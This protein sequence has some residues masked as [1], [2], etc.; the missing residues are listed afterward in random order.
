MV[1]RTMFGGF[2]IAYGITIVSFIAAVLNLLSKF[3]T[4]L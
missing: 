4:T 2:I 1:V 3:W